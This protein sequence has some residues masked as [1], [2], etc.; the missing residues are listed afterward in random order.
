MT[1]ASPTWVPSSPRLPP[2]AVDP[3]A[4]AAAWPNLAR[5]EERRLIRAALGPRY[6]PLS[7]LFTPRWYQ[8]PAWAALVIEQ[9]RRIDWVMHRR[10][11]KD[12]TAWNAWIWLAANWRVGTYFYSLPTLTQARRVIWRGMTASTA[13]GDA[14]KFLR[15]IPDRLIAREGGRKAINRTELSVELTNG[16]IIQLIGGDNYDSIVGTNAMGICFSEWSLTDPA[17]LDYFRPMI[18]NNDGVLAFI[19]T[20]RGHN[21]AKKTHD[22]Y[23]R[24]ARENPRR[25]FSAAMSAAETGAITPEQIAEDRE[26][27]MSDAMIA[28]EYGIDFDVANE[29]SYYGALMTKARKEG[30]VGHYPYDPTLTVYTAWDIG[31]SDHTAIWFAQVRGSAVY[32]IDYYA[33]HGHGVD[34]YARALEDRRTER[35]YR[36]WGSAPNVLAKGIGP[37]DLRRHDPKDYRDYVDEA[38]KFKLAFEVLPQSSV[39]TGIERVRQL[40]PRCYFD[41]PR[42]GRGVE[43]LESYSKAWNDA[44]KV[45]SDTPRHDW[46][47]HPADAFRYLALG[48]RAE[49]AQQPPEKR[50]RKLP[51]FLR[52]R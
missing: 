30:R 38:R 50:E 4:L 8:L 42:T 3:A 23:Q 43:A 20:P 29:G 21:H 37:H 39:N 31:G 40:L 35:G 6:S 22:R 1:S 19:Y 52:N 34:H 49:Q 28:Q 18:T 27:G 46:A 9:R 33:D 47:S 48:L 32:L 25:Y 17:A 11:G 51:G 16:S 45:W 26:E 14:T 41:L 44:L 10:G 7:P 15:Y 24:L 2:P 5:D 36:Y 13:D 12:L